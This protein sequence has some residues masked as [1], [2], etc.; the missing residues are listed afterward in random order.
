MNE[1]DYRILFLNSIGG[2]SHVDIGLC[3]NA[4]FFRPN[5]MEEQVYKAGKS[6]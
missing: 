1:F 2:I 5:D 6:V 3:E 4:L